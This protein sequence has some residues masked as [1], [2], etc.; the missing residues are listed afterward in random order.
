M[1][2]TMLFLGTG[3]ADQPWRDLERDSRVRGSTAT[4]VNGRLLLDCGATTWRDLAHWR[5][6]LPPLEALLFTHTHSD[7]FQPADVRRLAEAAPR[8]EIWCTRQGCARLAE[9]GVPS[10]RLHAL[11]PG[12]AFRAAG[13]ECL[14]LPAMHLVEDPEEPCVHY[15]LHDLA[16][17]RKL[18][19]ALDGAWTTY[20]AYRRLRQ[21]TLD[22][23]VWDCTMSAS[24]DYRIFEHS[25]LDMLDIQRRTFANLGILA[26]NAPV[27][28]DHL[29]WT[30]WPQE[31]E[32]ARR[33]AAGHGFLLAQDGETAEW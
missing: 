6:P 20:A 24:G 23:L 22:A 10:A 4:L 12:E 13:F 2:N 15:L 3:A 17:G 21:H 30:L 27:Y 8:L 5:V 28:L 25:N 32:A 19:Y 9:A 29:A 18:Y 7:H 33:L 26:P 11:T 14:P 16:S 31:R 1:G